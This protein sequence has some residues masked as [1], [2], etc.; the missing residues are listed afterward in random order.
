MKKT[1]LFAFFLLSVFSATAQVTL[2]PGIRAGANFSTLTNTGLDTK[3]D[4]YVGAF[5]ALKLTRFYTMQP[6][7]TYSRQG[8]EGQLRYTDYNGYADYQ[9]VDIELQYISLA[10]VNKF[11]LTDNFNVHLGPT[12]DIIANSPGSLNADVDLGLTAG[13]GYTL[14]FGL[15]IEAR[16]KKGIIN[17]LDEYYYDYDYNYNDYGWGNTTNLVFSVGVSYSFSVTG[18]TK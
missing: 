6:E 1:V 13:V 8:A 16:V 4:F 17:T 15:T 3:T 9:N 11:T 5:A 2:K 10:L 18:A 7:I 12:F 14:P